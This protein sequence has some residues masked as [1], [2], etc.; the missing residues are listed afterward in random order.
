MAK[1]KSHKKSRARQ[2]QKIVICK[3]VIPAKHVKTIPVLRGGLT[4]HLIL[5]YE[6]YKYKNSNAKQIQQ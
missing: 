2:I 6:K 5:P 1:Q 3:D 4:N